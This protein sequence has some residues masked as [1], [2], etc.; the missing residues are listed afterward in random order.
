VLALGL[1]LAVF[2]VV[3]PQAALS[4]LKFVSASRMTLGSIDEGRI[5]GGIS[6][7]FETFA[8]ASSE[9]PALMYL[10]NYW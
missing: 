9:C 8:C 10:D 6:W 7:A 3:Y 2:A 5:V 4:A 1:L